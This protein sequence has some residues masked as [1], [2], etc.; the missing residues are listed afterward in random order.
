MKR[1]L[2][3]FLICFSFV[4]SLDATDTYDGPRDYFEIR[5]YHFA[6]KEQETVIDDYL[7]NAFLPALHKNNR[8]L[9]GV[10]KPIANDTAADK[11]IFVL[12]PHKSIKDFTELPGKLDRDKTYQTAGATYINAAYTKPVY[13]RMETILLYGFEGM[14]SVGKPR[15]NG[16]K[17]EN[18]YE[19]RSYE[20]HTEKISRNKIDMFNKGDEIGLFKRL[21][22]NSVF[23]AQVL[24]GSRMPNLMY[25]TSFNSMEER[26]AHW[27]AFFADP[28]WKTLSADPNYKN[29][30]SK[31][32]I[33]FLKSV[34]YSDL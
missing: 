11:R 22:F 27:K 28:H 31:N 34:E 3:S 4:Q 23:Y 24:A 29:N 32:E 19:L 30:V 20:G 2:L 1:L 21:E 7:K 5:V 18:I 13:S 26:D 12:I 10:F 8:K 25:M 6:T 14:G 9:V 16:K 15:L 17:A 33:T